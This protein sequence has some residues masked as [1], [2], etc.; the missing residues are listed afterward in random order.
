M[1]HKLIKYIEQCFFCLVCIWEVGS[2]SPFGSGL[3]IFRFSL[4]SISAWW[5]V[6]EMLCFALTFSLVLCWG[7]WLSGSEGCLV[8]SISELCATSGS[9]AP[10]RSGFPCRYYGPLLGNTELCWGWGGGSSLC[11][12]CSLH[13]CPVFGLACDGNRR[14]DDWVPVLSPST[15]E[16]DFLPDS[17]HS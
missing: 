11:L 4:Q 12:F 14:T 7:F 13:S 9:Q 6:P 16:K 8:Q 10:R 1:G 3:F 15:D 17:F 2:F 5:V